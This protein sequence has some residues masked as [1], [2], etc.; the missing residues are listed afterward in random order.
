MRMIERILPPIPSVG[1]VAGLNAVTAWLNRS[2]EIG[3]IEAT[4][5]NLHRL[6]EALDQ[7]ADVEDYGLRVEEIRLNLE[8]REG[9]TNELL[10]RAHA[11]FAEIVE[12]EFLLQKLTSNPGTLK[13][14]GISGSIPPVN[15]DDYASAVEELKGLVSGGGEGKTAAIAPRRN[16]VHLLSGIQGDLRVL[17]AFESSSHGDTYSLA[18]DL[19]QVEESSYRVWHTLKGAL[20][21]VGEAGV[22][23]EFNSQLQAIEV[24]A[25]DL[26]ADTRDARDHIGEVH[27]SPWNSLP[28]QGVDEEDYRLVLEESRD[29]RGDDLTCSVIA[30]Q[31]T[32]ALEILFKAWS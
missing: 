29:E 2:Q 17:L 4:V 24:L 23:D 20:Y 7:I 15:P 22:P 11:F 18:K 21:L 30:D 26:M 27:S 32:Q 13:S 16:L 31:L 10:D 1:T 5:N 6:E 3:N 8:E 28:P 9:P 14:L 12:N 19:D 25:R